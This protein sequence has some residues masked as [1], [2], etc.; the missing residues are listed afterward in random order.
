MSVVDICLAVTTVV[1]CVCG[2]VMLVSAT[3]VMVC[4]ADDVLRRGW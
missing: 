1:A 2:S 3:V 4:W